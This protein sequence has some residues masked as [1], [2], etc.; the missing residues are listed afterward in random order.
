MKHKRVVIHYLICGILAIV[1]LCMTGNIANISG[2][3]YSVIE[4]LLK[5]SQEERKRYDWYQAFVAGGNSWIVLL[6]PVIAALPTI[7]LF[8][9]EIHTKYYLF[10][11]GRIGVKKYIRHTFLNAV[12]FGFLVMVVGILLYMLCVLYLFPLQADYGF[13]EVIGEDRT[14]RFWSVMYVLLSLSLWSSSM[15]GLAYLCA[16]LF[17]SKYVVLCIP[18]LLNYLTQ[19]LFLNH[20][21]GMSVLCIF[22]SYEV[23]NRIWCARYR[24]LRI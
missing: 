24:G 1:V 14:Q 23:G 12:A 5:F 7:P 2:K 10:G 22:L 21:Y 18:L 17:T 4:L 13:V 20:P 6:L 8:V 3:N 16:C 19:N 11:V 9:D 15:A